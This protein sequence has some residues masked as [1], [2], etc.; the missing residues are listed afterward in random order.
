[1][2]KP[3]SG[4]FVGLLLAALGCGSEAEETERATIQLKNDF[5]NPDMAYQP[6]WTICESSYLGVEF[7]KLEL[8][9]TSDPQ[10]VPPG[11]DYVLIVGAWDDPTCAPEHCLPLASKDEEEVVDGQTRTIALSMPNHQGPC[12]PEGIEPI[13]E[14]QYERIRELWPAYGFAPYAE[15]TENAQCS[16][17]GGSPGAA[18][19]GGGGAG[20]GGLGGVGGA[21]G[22]G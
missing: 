14:A 6:P 22:S 20:D 4:V 11:L 9:E 3:H 16:P 15:R 10:T 12:P 13:P 19:A 7:G 17:S 18:G 1:M 8:G 21:A 5:D 2:Y